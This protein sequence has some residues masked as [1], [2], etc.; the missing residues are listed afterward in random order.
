M[1]REYEII[2]GPFV[3]NVGQVVIGQ[4]SLLGTKRAIKTLHSHV[5]KELI[6]H[7]AKR[8]SSLHS[9]NIVQIFDFFEEESGPAIV[10]EYCPTGLDRYLRERL[11]QTERMIP[12]EEARTLLQG[13]LEGLDAAHG[14]GIVHGD[15]KADN[16]RIGEDE[17]AKLSDFG[18]A[19]GLEDQAPVFRGS[20]NW[21]APEVARGEGEVT[22]E[23]DLFSFGILA[24]LVLSGRH[25]FYY[26]D[27]SGLYSAQD[28]ILS[29]TFRP[30][31]LG[32]YR[33]DLPGKLA[34]LVM[35][36]LSPGM[37]R[38]EAASALKVALLAQP[39]MTEM[40]PSATADS[41]ETT[42]PVDLRGIR[43]AYYDAK[44]RFFHE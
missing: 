25:P 24:Y 38:A 35:A 14:A 2:E 42:E 26:D 10:M 18:A 5:N 21:M 37:P 8:Q 28:N 33:S 12:Y 36:L 22:A 3:G 30:V 15:I 31:H 27:P 7:E 6:I 34:D 41:G 17:Q 4:H 44:W 20:A 32:R 19:R 11:Q 43:T 29:D 16:I 13:I 40:A 1:L 9:P 23:S 39:D